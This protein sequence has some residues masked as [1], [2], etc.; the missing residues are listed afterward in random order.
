MEGVIPSKEFNEQIKKTVRESLRRDRGQPS[1]Q[2]R[3]HKKGTGGG[4]CADWWHLMLMS[5]SGG[6]PTSGTF[7]LD[8]VVATSGAD[9]NV[10]VTV[11]YNDTIATL[12]TTLSAESDL[13]DSSVLIVDVKG[14]PL[15]RQAI[16]IGNKNQNVPYVKSMDWSSNSLDNGQPYLIPWKPIV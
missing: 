9:A 4:I 11:N 3:W 15:H 8:L 14:G 6:F 10:S 12:I 16:A 1:R 5:D 13:L 7:S 2:G